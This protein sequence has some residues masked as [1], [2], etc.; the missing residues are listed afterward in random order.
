MRFYTIISAFSLA[1][2]SLQGHAEESSPHPAPSSASVGE[3]LRDGKSQDAFN[4]AKAG[5]DSGNSEQQFNLALIYWQGLSIPQN[6]QEAIRWVTLSAVGGYKKALAARAQ[7]LKSA[8]PSL[9]QK[10]MEWCRQ[11]L[12]KEAEQGNNLALR[13]MSIS[14][15]AEL[16]FENQ[17]ESYFWASLA[18]AMGDKDMARRRDT[19]TQALKPADVLKTQDRTVEWFGKFRQ[20]QATPTT[21]PTQ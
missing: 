20:K 21:A 10:A 4:L 2:L 11:R 1:L 7:M 13:A 17:L 3:L 19:L 14:Y 18:V 12:Q 6:Y 16:G 9:A 15:S 5:A 8:D